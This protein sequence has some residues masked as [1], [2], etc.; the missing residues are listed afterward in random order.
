MP[1]TPRRERHDRPEGKGTRALG[2]PARLSRE[3]VVTAA[4]SVVRAHGLHGLTMRALA[5]ELGATPMALYRHVGDRDELALLV[6]DALFSGL[7]LPD[8]GLPAIAWLRELAH[9]IRALGRA[10]PG[11]MDV[12]LEEGPVVRSTLV[13]LDRVVRKLHGEGLGWKT[14]AAVHN[15]FLSWVAATVRREERWAARG[16]GG[17][18]PLERFLGVAATMPAAEFP[19]LAHVLAHMPG[20]DVDTEFERSLDFMLDGVTSKLATAGARS[21]SKRR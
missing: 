13:I 5:D 15:T 4:V 14:A 21:A 17:T 10:H 16:P 8:D 19:G 7:E 3:L 20:A 11:V 2:R 9:Q 6:I 1:R 18:P 12:L